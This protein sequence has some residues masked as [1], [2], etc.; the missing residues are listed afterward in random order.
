MGSKS[1]FVSGR[2]QKIDSSYGGQK[3]TMLVVG[4]IMEG[5]QKS[6]EIIFPSPSV[7]KC[8]QI[9]VGRNDCEL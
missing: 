2:V 9:L 4:F 1:Y 8:G 7:V 6:E 3:E 5:Q